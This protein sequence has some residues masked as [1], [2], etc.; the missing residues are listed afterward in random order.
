MTMEFFATCS[1]G[2]EKVL[3]DEL[4]A[5]GVHGVRP[6]KAGVAFQGGPEDA[7]RAL[8][9]SRVASRVLLTLARIDARDADALY[10]GVKAIPWEEHVPAEGTIAIDA[11]GTNGRLRDTRFTALRSKDAVCD[12]LRELR[13]E[14][15]DVDTDN[16][17][18]RINVGIHDNKATVSL[19]LA[20]AS[21]DRRGYA[22]AGKPQGAPLR[23]NLAAGMLLLSGWDERSR[24]G[25][26]LLNPFAGPGTL[27]IEAAMIAADI[28]PQIYRRNWGFEG[29]LGHDEE[30][31]GRVLDEADARAEAGRESFCSQITAWDADPAALAYAAACA[32][33]A[34]VAEL[35][36]FLP[37]APQ[38]AEQP[39]G[40]LLAAN[41][42]GDGRFASLAQMPALYAQLAAALRGIEGA[43]TLCLLAADAL[44]DSAL[45]LP[46]RQE[47]DARNGATEASVRIYSLAA[48]EEGEAVLPAGCTLEVAGRSVNVGDAAVEQ[49]AARLAK[50]YKQRRKWAKKEGISCYR[51]YDADL[52]DYNL[53]VDVYNGAG[54]DEGKM[55]VHVAEYAAPKKI[56]PAK[57]ARRMTDALAVI[58]AVLGVD[59]GDV[60]AK[61][62]LRAKGGSQYARKEREAAYEG[63]KLITQENGLFFE[64][65]L[66][67]RLDT[68]LFLD[69]R[70][71]RQL[72]RQLAPGKAFL[73][74]F[75]Y[76]GSASVYAAAGGAKFTTTVDMSN[77]YQEWT[78]R[79]F[80]LNGME[81]EHMEL[82][83]A[84]VLAW[85]QE[86]RHSRN[87]WDLIFVD[88]PTFSNSSKMGR[89][90][91]DVQ[92]DHA[93]LL[94]GSS[95]LLTRTGAIVFSCNL[96]DFK[97]DVET[98][99]KAGVVIND[100]TARTIPDDFQ[101]NQ[102]I[103]K[104]YVLRRG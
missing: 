20:G 65:D 55:L 49:F 92:A 16:P 90:T 98:L 48:G 68:G 96:R 39:Q 3:G 45:G 84:D 18:V 63:R 21:L 89:R 1:R 75:A 4:R 81:N 101:R 62:R 42:A 28:A 71:T 57:A 5:A 78:R 69:H 72:L 61:Q 59:P 41:L 17:S 44:A 77:T 60:F 25:A 27:A 51:L 102:K 87:R 15:P 8:L 67:D 22:S 12:R 37:Q 50:V 11:R 29:W 103:H 9:W 2:F 32:K 94:I 86:Q 30:A 34:G 40:T 100:I 66:G 73:N 93:E 88:P 104:C 6:L 56:D 91:W 47:L 85:V 54:P 31:W 35:V 95:R 76:T 70:D 23:E 36:S 38:A 80:R 19:D 26:S 64:V 33:R 52:P 83:R 14:R 24:S 10:E 82:E 99:R 74:L 58:P 53:A 79:N 97:P 7:Y 13:G 43:D 46:L